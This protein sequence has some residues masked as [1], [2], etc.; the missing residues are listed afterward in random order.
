VVR[1]RIIGKFKD[2]TQ[3]TKESFITKTENKPLAEYKETLCSESPK[4]KTEVYAFSNH[5][6]WRD[7]Q[8]IEKNIDNIHITNAR[9]SSN[10]LDKV[11]DRLIEK[12]KK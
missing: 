4:S 9:K 7:I 6:I 10:E 2:K 1:E 5:R 12:K 3:R 11:V 8:S